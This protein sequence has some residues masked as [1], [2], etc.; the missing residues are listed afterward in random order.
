MIPIT[1]P[2]SID[3]TVAARPTTRLIRAPHTIS[4]R[5][6][7]P[8]S[9]V[10]RG[11]PAVGGLI[12]SPVAWVTL[13]VLGGNSTGASSASAM[14]TTSTTRPSTPPRWARNARQ[15]EARGARRRARVTARAEVG[16]TGSNPGSGHG[17][18]TRTRGSSTAYMRSAMMLA[19]MTPMENRR[20]V[21]WSRAMSG[22]R[23][24]S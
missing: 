24:A 6:E 7:R 3:M 17:H 2:I 11:K 10:P 20:N 4:A 18:Q 1:V 16:L 19:A 13:I 23:R 12:G 5:I 21:A 8:L 9:S 22:P 15:V 14:N